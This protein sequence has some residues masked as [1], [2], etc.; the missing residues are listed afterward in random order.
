[1]VKYLGN[2]T[3]GSVF[4]VKNKDGQEYAA[5]VL[6]NNPSSIKIEKRTIRLFKKS[7]LSK[8]EKARFP[9]IIET[10]NYGVHYVIIMSLHGQSFLDILEKN[11][12]RGKIH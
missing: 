1:M 7:K 2:G 6:N 3:F 11:N 5:K 10:F 12:Y 8:E 9:E 4:L